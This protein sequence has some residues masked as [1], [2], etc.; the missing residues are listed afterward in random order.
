[1]VRTF[2]YASDGIVP[3][4]G[5]V[6]FVVAEDL[7]LAAVETIQTGHGAKPHKALGVFE[8]G[9][10]VVI[11]QP[12]PAVDVGKG[13]VSVLRAGGKP[14]GATYDQQAMSSHYRLKIGKKFIL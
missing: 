3:Y 11:G 9:V 6:A 12:M 13:I 1:V 5:G 2:G 14:E 7:E 4:G 8:N 10:Y